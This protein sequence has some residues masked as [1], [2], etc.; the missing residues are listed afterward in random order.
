MSHD[1]KTEIA[2]GV[3]FIVATVAYSLG[4]YLLGSILQSPDYL[5]LASD[6]AT[7][8]AAGAL[9][10][11]VDSVAV[12]GIGILMYRILRRHSEDA[13]LAYAGARIVES[14]LFAVSVAA[15][16]TLLTLSQ[17]FVQ[18]G[19]PDAP[20]YQALGGVVLA[21]GDWANLLGL[22]LAFALSALILNAA[23]YKARLVPR[24]LSGW[25]FIGA[26][27]VVVNFLLQLFGSDPVVVL[28]IVIAV[29]EMVFA[30]W[31]ILKGFRTSE[32]AA[33]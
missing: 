33:S 15:I 2:V 25:G 18:A 3:L 1:R 4:D 8:V 31:L 27:L 9:L 7:R 32:V 21:A 20:Y 6:N 13:A 28:F 10:V 16:L 11:L 26:V 14:V 12:A 30:L 22:G 17:E 5:T 19:A 23:L 24:W 29:Q